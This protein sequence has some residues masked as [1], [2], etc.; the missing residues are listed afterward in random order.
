MASRPVYKKI[1]GRAFTL[2][3]LQVWYWGEASDKRQWT[4]EKQPSYPYIVFHRTAKTVDIYYD[5][6]GIDWIK[7]KILKQTKKD[8]SFTDEV[9]AKYKSQIEKIQ[10]ILN[11][12]PIL[13]L[14][15]L[16]EFTEYVRN[17]YPWFEAL[18]WSIEALETL[19]EYKKELG[20]LMEVRQVTEKLGPALDSIIRKSIQAAYPNSSHFA[21]VILLEEAFENRIPKKKE[22][23]TRKKE[24][25]YTDNQVFTVKTKNDIESK[26]KII[27]EDDAHSGPVSEIRGQVAYKGKVRGKVRLVFGVEQIPEFKAGEILVA[28]TT[29]PDL[30]PA[31]KKAAALVGDEGGIISHTAIVARELKIPCVIGTKIATKVLKNGDMVEVDAEKGIVKILR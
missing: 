8:R 24:Y 11:T 29:T 18:W 23:Q 22:L 16:Q 9:A 2:G 4:P 21:N 10:K 14:S 31:M 17:I 1:F 12:E 13:S 20:V 5:Q 25:Y 26:Y 6:T 28:T 30:L 7:N 15:K 3:S 19:P 27:L